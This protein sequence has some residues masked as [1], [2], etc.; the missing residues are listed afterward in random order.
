MSNQW[1]IDGGGE[2]WNYHSP[3]QPD[4][5]PSITGTV[6]EIE[7]V[8]EIDYYSKKPK[9]YEGSNNPRLNLK[10]IIQGASGKELPW[11]VS[12]NRNS[13]S[14]KA[15][16][17]AI[18]AYDPS[19]R[20]LIDVGGLKIQVSTQGSS[21]EYGTNNHR[22]WAVQILGPGD[23]PYRGFVEFDPSTIQVQQ[24]QQM[25]QQAQM[26]QQQQ[27][28]AM[29]GQAVPPSPGNRTIDGF[30]DPQPQ[31][32]MPDMQQF[33]Q[34]LNN[35]Q[36]QM[37]QQMQPQ[38]VDYNTMIPNQQQPAVNGNGLYDEDIPF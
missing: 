32:Q 8:Q 2:R 24:D 25:N 16:V 6:V 10:L 22:P 4:Y 17:D 27:N 31:Q 29:Y 12:G 3:D 14:N 11:V 28:M 38:Q 13:E 36:Q 19:L 37:Q 33:N 5:M 20:R 21:K 7:E 15:L 18:K 34:S 23:A 9:F 1:S 35:V 26:I 30:N